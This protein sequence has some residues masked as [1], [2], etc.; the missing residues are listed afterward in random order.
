MWKSKVSNL[1]QFYLLK[2]N[3]FKFRHNV[4]DNPCDL[5]CEK[6]CVCEAGYLR[7][8][9]AG[10]CVY[11]SDCN[12]T[13]V[14]PNVK[15]N[16]NVDDKDG[17]K[18]RFENRNENSKNKN[19]DDNDIDDEVVRIKPIEDEAFRDRGRIETWMKIYYKWKIYCR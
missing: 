7:Q 6:A 3:N 13:E 4:K 5:S 12:E 9:L 15:T 2:Y 14:I 11:V 19:D 10:E 1:S 8:G 18:P 17:T 16:K